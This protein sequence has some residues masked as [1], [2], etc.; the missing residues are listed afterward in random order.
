[1]GR[2]IE[3][4]RHDPNLRSNLRFLTFRNSSRPLKG[5]GMN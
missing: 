3:D 2:K 4:R 5:S 1:M